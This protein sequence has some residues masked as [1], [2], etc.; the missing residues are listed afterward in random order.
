MEGEP[1]GR[2]APA[3]N[4]VGAQRRCG[5]GPSS[6]AISGLFT[7]GRRAV[8]WRVNLPGLQA[9]FRM[10]VAAQ[11]LGFEFSALRPG[12][13]AAGA[14]AGFEDPWRPWRAARLDTSTFLASG[15][16][17]LVEGAALIQR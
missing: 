4:R 13:C 14:A 16:A 1:A 7:P 8:T 5:S 9:P 12:R 2:L 10:R 11:A 6:S 15:T 17:Q 3:G